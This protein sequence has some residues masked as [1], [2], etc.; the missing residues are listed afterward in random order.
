MSLSR[1]MPTKG[2]E[3]GPAA[4]AR[5]A[6]EHKASF[7]GASDAGAVCA[8]RIL[9]KSWLLTKQHTQAQTYVRI[10]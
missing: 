8:L 2:E 1:A 3:R 6:R 4:L 5:V 10:G 7:A 9:T